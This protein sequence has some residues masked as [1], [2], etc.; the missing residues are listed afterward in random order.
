MC[1]YENGFV[2]T[3]YH[4]GSPKKTKNFPGNVTISQTICTDFLEFEL[5]KLTGFEISSKCSGRF[6]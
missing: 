2:V 1:S 4:D 3:F 6:D 5:F